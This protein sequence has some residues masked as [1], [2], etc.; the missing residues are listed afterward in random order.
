MTHIIKATLLFDGN[1]GTSTDRYITIENDRIAEVSETASH[2]DSEGIVTPAFIDPHSHIG[3]EREG[4]PG[5]EGE[6]NDE[7]GQILPLV[8]PVDSLYFDDRAFSDAVDFG[9]LYSCVVPGSGNLIGGKAKVIR[10][11]ARY[12]DEAVIKDYGYKMALGYN[13]RSTTD[14]KGD[15]PTTRMGIYAMLEKR[16]DEVL[17]KKEKAALAKEKKLNELSDKQA[18]GEINET[19][20]AFEADV[21]EREYHLSF[22]PEDTALLELLSG[23]KIAKVHVHK[24]DD[25]LYLIKLV[26]KYGLS[27]TCDHACDVFHTEIFNK[28][29]EKEIPVVYGPIGSVG[30][31]VE[32]K[33]A[34]YKNTAKI[35]AS[36]AFYTLMSDHPVTLAASLRDG[37]KFFLMHGMD[38]AEAI[39][40]LTGKSATVLGIDDQLGTVEAGKLASL[41]VWDRHPFHLGAVPTMVFAEGKQIR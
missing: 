5:R 9:V 11:F 41:L 17:L 33:H 21:I 2:W 16:F 1:G 36:D 38:E 26:E 40:L 31:K 18:K 8:D 7:I 24:E 35:M 20:H 34:V 22:G 29:A 10:N 13:P 12:R 37:L 23:E 28:L 25:I 3:M 39:S 19:D 27:V 4:E 14:W 15:R 30:Y 6:A 32:L